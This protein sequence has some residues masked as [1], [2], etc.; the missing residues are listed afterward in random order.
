VW[1]QLEYHIDVCHVT[2]G[3]HIEHLKKK[4][5][6][7]FPLAV[8]NSIKPGPLVFLLQ[9]FVITEKITKHPV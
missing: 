7:I 4:T 9:M 1:Q 3:A 5:F 2:R 8:K 6:F